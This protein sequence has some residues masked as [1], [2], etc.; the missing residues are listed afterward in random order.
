MSAILLGTTA[1][2]A[3]VKKKATPARKPAPTATKQPIKST[4]AALLPVD[5]NVIIGKLP[6]GLT[7]YIRN[8]GQPKSKA[9]LILV[10]KV[11]S[12]EETDAQLGMANFIQH[13]AFKGTRDFTKNDITAFLKK[14][15]ERFGPDTTAFTSYDETVYQ[16][17]LPTD[18][19][20]TFEAGFSLI[21]NWAAYMKFNQAEINA[22][23]TAVTAQIKANSQYVQSRLQQQTLPALL[24]NSMYALRPPIGKEN[25]INTFDE[26]S[27][28]SF[29][30]Q[31][32][33][34]DLQAVI[35][36]GDFDPK[37]VEEL[38]KFNF[39]SLRNPSPEKPRPQFAVPVTAG[40]AVKFFTDKD[41]PY[42]MIQLV[43]RHPQAII[44]TPADYMQNI[45]VLLFNQ[46]LN[47]RVAELNEVPSPALLFGQAA[48][49]SLVG[50]Q[51]AFTIIA[52]AKSGGLE[53]AVK[54]IVGETQRVK[55]F[56]FT[57][58]ELE[59]A[60]QNA[61]EQISN[62][63]NARNNNLSGN[64]VAEYE[65][66]FL[67]GQAIPGLDYE[68]NYY[69]N[70]IGK[71]NL[72]EMDALAI[73]YI[74]D[75]NRTII[76]QAPNSE[77]DKL[78]T[79][80]TLLKWIADSGTGL[81]AYVDY[82]SN[83]L[84][85]KLPD[86]GKATSVKTDSTLLVDNVVLSNGVKVILKSTNFTNGQILFTGY[87]LGGTSLA[88]DQDLTSATFAAP[89]IS[90][91]GVAGF[92]QTELNKMLQG[93]NI[94]VSPYISETA[95]G[96]SGYTASGNF[97]DAL[98]LLYLYFT[99]PRKDEA[100]W[101]TTI[102][103]SKSLLTNKVNDPG[104]VYQDT[105]LSVLSNYK[106]RAMPVTEAQLNA[107]SLDKAY[108]FYKDRF[109]DASGFTF[110]FTGS[111][112]TA[113]IMP[114]LEEY[115]GSLP[116][117]NSKE[118]YKNL[119]I[120]PPAGQVTKIIHKG[121]SD[122]AS[123]QLIFSGSYEYNEA[124]NIQ[125]DAL[126]EFLNVRLVDSL[127][128]ESGVLSPGVRVSYVKIPEGQYKIYISFLC[129]ANNVDAPVTY[130]LNEVNK[131][132]QTGPDANGV[133]RFILKEA[134]SIRSQLN[135]NTFWEASLTAAAQNQQDPDKIL[136]HVQGLNEVSVQSAKDTAN[137]YLGNNMIKLILLPEK[138]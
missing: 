117:I 84:M 125:M 96:V 50:K 118:T 82:K 134:R 127:K 30:T 42:T 21:A 111:F 52:I 10:N 11:G 99:N 135:Q 136:L 6:N 65:R 57:L 54:A 40:T 45:R 76:L 8:N 62:S 12:I 88:S 25:T 3:Q 70:N 2:F 93:K 132:K 51:D 133:Q 114:Y 43:S 122:K 121:T 91:S 5:P 89:V 22:G 129:D 119:G 17:S 71:I 55:K 101:T 28:K 61:L 59:R 36:I 72:A 1:T 113:E 130:M 34:P 33:R 103:Q 13:M 32:Y 74:S 100:V 116:S 41:Y 38:I 29:Y 27:L 49:G 53:N 86:P 60:K 48:Y 39:S 78:P 67:T 79:E 109:A 68:Y 20:K 73:K 64:F 47:N 44:K 26:A 18:T 126:E 90:N 97:E 105:I 15:G 66:N 102:N 7:Y 81:A 106:A 110:T 19:Q 128:K 123:V 137:K 56:G 98:Q 94:S 107:A 37:H 120:R 83:P 14:S 16:L 124:N 23:K 80:Q 9:N 112:T 4:D 77:K 46:I 108:S 131:F 75:Q 31:W 95:Q 138:K 85:D 63:Y 92:N 115:L 35:A 104:S 58:T 87:S 69:V 24:N